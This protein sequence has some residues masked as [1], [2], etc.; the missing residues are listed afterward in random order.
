[1]DRLKQRCDS[2]IPREEREIWEDRYKDA[3]KEL[4]N[5]RQRARAELKRKNLERYNREQLIDSERQL[6]GLIVDEGVKS[7]LEMTEFM[8]PEYMALIDALL[9]LQ[10]WVLDSTDSTTSPL[11]GIAL[12]ANLPTYGNPIELPISNGRGNLDAIEIVV[13]FCGKIDEIFGIIIS[14]AIEYR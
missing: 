5:G 12:L 14:K 4:N 8:T 11:P 2:T 7:V 13:E 1:V 6:S 9:T 3:L 10:S